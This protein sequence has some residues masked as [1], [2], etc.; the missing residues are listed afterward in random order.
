ME[1]RYS[2]E[3]EELMRVLRDFAQRELAPRSSQWDETGKVPWDVWR[4]MGEVGL[5]GLRT[6]EAFGGQGADLVTMGIATEEIARGD[7]G[8]T[9]AIQLAGLAGEIVGGNGAPEVQER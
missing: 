7:F 8:S 9:T 4:Q 6:P 1:F 2:P 5:L 3:Q